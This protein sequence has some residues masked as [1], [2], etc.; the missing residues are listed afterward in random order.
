MNE[1]HVAHGLLAF[2]LGAVDDT[3]R[4]IIE[5]HLTGCRPCLDSFFELKRRIEL[6]AD[7]EQRPSAALR[8]RV[9]EDV[10]RRIPV[11]PDRRMRLWVGAAVAA[12]IVVGMV[13]TALPKSTATREGRNP[14]F[15]DVGTDPQ[16]Q[17]AL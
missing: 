17:S 8:Q 9:R 16:A 5:E 14:V 10:A 6:A 11:V 1:T 13:V 3:D 7:P 12:A 2:Q 15:I 4:A